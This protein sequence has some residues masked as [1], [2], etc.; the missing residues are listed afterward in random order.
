MKKYR[1]CFGEWRDY[2]V[3]VVAQSEEVAVS[4]ACLKLED[5][6]P[7]EYEV[8]GGCQLNHLIRYGEEVPV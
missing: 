7:G 6:E 4:M 8:G 3:E 1:V 2:V 5:A